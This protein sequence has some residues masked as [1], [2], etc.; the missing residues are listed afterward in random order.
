MTVAPILTTELT[1]FMQRSAGFQLL[2]G[3]FPVF[4]QLLSLD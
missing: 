1:Q 2:S 4:K 3:P